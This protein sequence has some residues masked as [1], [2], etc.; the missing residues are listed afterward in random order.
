MAKRPPIS[1][2][3]V[4]KMRERERNVGL[5]HDDAARWLDENAPQEEPTVPK[6][7]GKSKLLHQWRQKQRPKN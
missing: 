7:A 4:E 2:Q 6:S 5:E 3:R 1:R